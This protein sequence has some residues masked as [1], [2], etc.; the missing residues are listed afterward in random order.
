MTAASSTELAA[1]GW[2]IAVLNLG[3]GFPFPATETR[4]AAGARLA[5]LPIGAPIVVDGLAFG[6]LPEAA[7]ALRA[8]HRSGRA[9]ASSACARNRD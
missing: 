9:G 7:E 6:A 4:A 5:A 8:T 3:D 2:R 1:L